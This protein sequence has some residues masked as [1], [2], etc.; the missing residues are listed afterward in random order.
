M[1]S[2]GTDHCRPID[3]DSDAE[4][5]LVAARM[6]ETLVEVL[7]RERGE[8]MYTMEWLRARV[9]R[10]MHPSRAVFVA[11]DALQEIATKPGGR[12][13]T[14][15]AAKSTGRHGWSRRATSKTSVRDQRRT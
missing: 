10:H 11:V 14:S 13:V 8:V 9:R 3:P 12:P 7:G 6:R 1:K 4:V 15:I 5:D 2:C